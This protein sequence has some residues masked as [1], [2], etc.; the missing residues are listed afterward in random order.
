MDV[1]SIVAERRRQHLGK[2]F[3]TVAWFELVHGLWFRVPAAS[4]RGRF[5]LAYK[6]G[7]FK[8][9]Q[10]VRIFSKFRSVQRFCT[11]P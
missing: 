8:H 2:E 11:R 1:T 10:W 4:E 7:L 6:E 3:H 5:Y 9:F